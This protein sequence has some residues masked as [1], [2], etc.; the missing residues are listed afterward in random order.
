MKY[1]KAYFTKTYQSCVELAREMYEDLFCNQINQLL[2]SF[3]KN[4]KIE[5][6]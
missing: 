1:A 6:G 3:P 5:S 2:H 4:H